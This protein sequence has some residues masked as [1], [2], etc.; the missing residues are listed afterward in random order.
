MDAVPD[1]VG[2]LADN[3]RAAS[4]TVTRRYDDA[5]R[6]HGLR[7]TQVAVLAQIRTL[8]PVSL[9]RLAGA[10]SS[11]RSVVARDVSVLERDG[12]VASV[13]DQDDRR[14][15]AISLTPLGARR[16]RVVAPAWRRAQRDMLDSLGPELTGQLLDVARRVVAALDDAG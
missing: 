6:G 13:V 16:L 3:L 8:Q 4:R 7:I 15:R 12:L 1:F 11:E 5:L 10:L 2:C 14:A 9:T